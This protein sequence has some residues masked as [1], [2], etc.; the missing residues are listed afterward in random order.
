[1]RGL[2]PILGFESDR[3]WTAFFV[4]PYHTER[5]HQPQLQ[6][7]SSYSLDGN[8]ILLL[9]LCKYHVEKGMNIHS[10]F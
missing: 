5:G 7:F 2:F 6:F 1:M 9:H 4:A 3:P 10:W 8:N